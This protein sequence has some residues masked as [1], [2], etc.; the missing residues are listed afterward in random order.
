MPVDDEAGRDW[1]AG[2]VTRLVQS[3]FGSNVAHWRENLPDPVA[4]PLDEVR[5]AI[6]DLDR[7]LTRTMARGDNDLA[8]DLDVVVGR[9]TRW[10]WPLL[11]ELD[12]DE[13]Y[14]G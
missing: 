4:V 12:E 10:V 9:M 11:R 3:A 5:V 14:D 8:H 6:S 7:L 2:T 1:Y 13:D